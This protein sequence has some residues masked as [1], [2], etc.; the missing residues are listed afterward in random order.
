[1]N[2]NLYKE[3]QPEQVKA[4]LIEEWDAYIIELMWVI[5]VE[6]ID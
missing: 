2:I 4:T 1:M 3:E 6:C 5:E